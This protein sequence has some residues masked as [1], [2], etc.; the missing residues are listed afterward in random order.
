MKKINYDYFVWANDLRSNS[1][2]GILGN[3]FL[4]KI[5][6]KDKIFFVKTPF[7]EFYIIKNKKKKLFK[8]N[9]YTKFYI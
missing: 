6:K 5:I 8:E 7:E 4:N 2:E 3:H 9:K 1:G